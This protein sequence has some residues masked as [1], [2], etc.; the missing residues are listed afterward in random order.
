MWAGGIP[1]P[2]GNREGGLSNTKLKALR[3]KAP[4][5]TGTYVPWRMT[6]PRR[7]ESVRWECVDERWVAISM[8]HG[9]DAGRAVVSNSEGQRERCDT[10]DEALAL[11]K[12]WRTIV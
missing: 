7:D 10:Y 4:T 11:A 12:R 5:L 1:L 3:P 9:A 2:G 6:P 8:G